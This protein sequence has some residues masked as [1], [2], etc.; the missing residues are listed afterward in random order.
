MTSAAEAQFVLGEATLHDEQPNKKWKLHYRVWRQ[1]GKYDDATNLAD[2]LIGQWQQAPRLTRMVALIQ[3]IMDTAIA[4]ADHIALMRD[5]DEA[6]GV[7]LDYL[8]LLVGIER[9]GVSDPTLDERFGFDTAGQPFD[10]APFRGAAVNDAI[11]PLPD[12]VYRRMVKARAIAV[13]GDGTIFSFAKAVKAMDA[14]ASCVRFP[15]HDG[16]GGH[17][18]TAVHGARRQHRRIAAHGGRPGAVRGSGYGARRVPGIHGN[19]HDGEAIMAT[20]RR[21]C[22]QNS[23][24]YYM[25]ITCLRHVV[26]RSGL[27]GRLTDAEPANDGRIAIEDLFVYQ[28]PQEDAT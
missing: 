28:I 19:A 18:A 17:H 27:L 26:E 23:M 7:W 15:R 11:Y 24:E 4:A 10:T 25:Q 13:F 21:H 5:I 1:N 12:P 6:E 22:T 3:N 14:N 9:P 16:D 2:L 20:C 8:G